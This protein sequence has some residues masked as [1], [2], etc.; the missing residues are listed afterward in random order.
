MEYLL[1]LQEESIIVSNSYSKFPNVVIGSV[2][3]VET[4]A[5]FVSLSWKL[6]HLDIS[7]LRSC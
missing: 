1:F 7:N 2:K 6:I 4:K 5:D 3:T